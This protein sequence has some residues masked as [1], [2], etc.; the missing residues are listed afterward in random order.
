MIPLQQP[1]LELVVEIQLVVIRCSGGRIL[2]EK[3][4][5]GQQAFGQLLVDATLWLNPKILRD[6]G[7]WPSK[8]VD[9][10]RDDNEPDINRCF[11]LSEI[12]ADG[13]G[14][15][16]HHF[17]DRLVA[18]GDVKRGIDVRI[19]DGNLAD[20][21]RRKLQPERR[22]ES[23]ERTVLGRIGIQRRNKTLHLLDPATKVTQP[24]AG[25]DDAEA[26]A[27]ASCYHARHR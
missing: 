10:I 20:S 17:V 21:L 2:W 1:G 22:L 18:V 24:G 25:A 4:W 15:Y 13:V 12:A 3:R 16:V 7:L 8:F 6:N 27:V 14:E 19:G 23:G 9:P 11:L 5:L 26:Q